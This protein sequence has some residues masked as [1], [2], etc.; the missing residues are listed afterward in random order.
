MIILFYDFIDEKKL[1]KKAHNKFPLG[2]L[3]HVSSLRAL[4]YHWPQSSRNVTSDL[5]AMIGNST[6]TDE[7]RFASRTFGSLSLMFSSIALRARQ[8]QITAQ[9]QI[10]F[11]WTR[12]WAEFYLF[13]QWKYLFSWKILIEPHLIL[14]NRWKFSSAFLHLKRAFQRL[15]R[16]IVE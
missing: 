4:K 14:R 7:D 8:L 10:I 16:A 13:S 11:T 3:R 2:A 9:H 1:R 5:K 12:P 6:N 15:T